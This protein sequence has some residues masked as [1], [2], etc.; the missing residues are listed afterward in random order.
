MSKRKKPATNKRM[1]RRKYFKVVIL[2]ASHRN[3]F[4]ELT[5]NYVGKINNLIFV[6]YYN[7]NTV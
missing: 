5:C 6:L 7:E 3:I 1:K 4:L 2:E